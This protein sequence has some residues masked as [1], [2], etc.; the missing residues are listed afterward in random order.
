[1]CGRL[2]SA[3]LDLGCLRWYAFAPADDHDEAM[4]AVRQVLGVELPGLR[5]TS[6]H[7]G[8]NVK[9]AREIGYRWG[10]PGRMHMAE[11]ASAAIEQEEQAYGGL[12]PNALTLALGAA[13]RGF[14]AAPWRARKPAAWEKLP[15]GIVNQPLHV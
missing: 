14:D 9:A 5:V 10:V 13:L 6:F 4:R 2:R 15:E 1:V 7:E 11:S 3:A 8:D 12:G